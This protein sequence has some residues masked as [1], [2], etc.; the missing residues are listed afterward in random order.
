MSCEEIGLELDE[1]F[2]LGSRPCRP[3]PPSSASERQPRGP[4]QARATSATR[5]RR[6]RCS[7]R[8]GVPRRGTPGA[9]RDVPLASPA[10]G[11]LSGGDDKG[12]RPGAT[13]ASGISILTFCTQRFS[14]RST[15]SSTSREAPRSKSPGNSDGDVVVFF[16]F[17]VYSLRFTSCSHFHLFCGSDPA[18]RGV[19][20]PGRT[21]SLS[22]RPALRRGRRHAVGAR[23][24]LVRHRPFPVVTAYS[25][26]EALFYLPRRPAA[27]HL[28]HQRH[29]NPADQRLPG[30]S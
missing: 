11:A 12:G 8:R 2:A 6:T 5:A 18:R 4:A 27:A 21:P 23:H 17:V 30:S 29:G 24:C 3:S 26:R 20:A 19:P 16:F 1:F 14:N 22:A 13:P 28:R 15:A 9:G 7:P 25:G 10:C